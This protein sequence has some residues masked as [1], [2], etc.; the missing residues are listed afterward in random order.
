MVMLKTAI[1]I[2]FL[3]GSCLAKVCIKTR[4]R[5]F[6][7]LPTALMP[8]KYRLSVQPYFPADN[9]SYPSEKNFTFDANLTIV[10]D[11]LDDTNNITLNMLNIILEKE[12]MGLTNLALNTKEDIKS[13][14]YDNKSQQVTFCPSAPLKAGQTYQLQL[15]YSG[16][17]DPNSLTGFYSSPYVEYGRTKYTVYIYMFD[18]IRIIRVT[19]HIYLYMYIYNILYYTLYI[20]YFIIIYYTKCTFYIY[21][22]I[23]CMY[24]VSIK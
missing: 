19:L 15:K 17:V 4:R 3:I 2:F 24:R 6:G 23:N 18:S 22:I 10:I 13:Y 16:K 7:Q 14:N 8:V 9:V 12:G 5:S 1:I 11:C 21:Y 20:I